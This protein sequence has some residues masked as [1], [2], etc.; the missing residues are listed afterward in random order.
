MGSLP[1]GVVARR[2]EIKG[3]LQVTFH[4]VRV[5]PSPT[6]PPGPVNKTEVALFNPSVLKF[7]GFVFYVFHNRNAQTEV[8]GQSIA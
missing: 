6:P 1:W 7:C 2:K 8:V 5:A 3:I 4:F